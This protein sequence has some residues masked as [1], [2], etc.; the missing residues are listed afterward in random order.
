[1]VSIA[2]LGFGVVGSGVYEVVKQRSH[3][4][5]VR[6]KAILD[7]KDFPEHEE[8]S[9]FVSGFDDILADNDIRIVVESIGGLNPTYEYSKKALQAGKYVITSNK[10]LVA[11]HGL[12]LTRIAHA[13]G[14]K[15]LFEASVGGGIPIIRP[16]NQC[17][18]GEK[19]SEIFGILNG[20]TNY[21]LTEMGKN[22]ESFE[23]ALTDAQAKGYA[24]L[25][26]TNDIEGHDTKRKIKI[27]AQLAFGQ[28][29]PLNDIATTGITQITLDDIQAAHKA[30]CALKLIG[31]AK[32]L[33]DGR[34]EC[35][36][37]P[38]AIPKENPL[39]GIEGVFNGIMIKAE[40]IGE[41]MFY[42]R[43]AGKFPTA[44]AVFADILEVIKEVS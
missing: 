8:K 20:T 1:M 38:M 16:L 12:E 40:P 31:H 10:E 26:P 14:V 42:G 41:V 23:R 17:L 30:E 34:V 18:A 25:D 27:L 2:I 33:D 4:M 35:T 7:I 29:I 32:Q 21:I 39:Y 36:V 11:E 28:E 43:G 22:G 5:D 9:L 24:E 37:K 44:S 6:V 19:I 3:A 13:H 15:Y